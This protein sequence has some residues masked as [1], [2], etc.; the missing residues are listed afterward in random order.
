[1]T[2]P[3]AADFREFDFPET[4]KIPASGERPSI[5]GND[6]ILREFVRRTV[7]YLI[8]LPTL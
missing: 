7:E 6:L 2:L 4:V 5:D 1:V 8:C 3:T